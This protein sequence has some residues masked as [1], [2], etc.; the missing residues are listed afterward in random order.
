MAH[1]RSY[2]ASVTTT[3]TILDV[4]AHDVLHPSVIL[5]SQNF[6]G[7]ASGAVNPDGWTPDGTRATSFAVSPLNVGSSRGAVSGGTSSTQGPATITRTITGLTVGKSTTIAARYFSVSNNGAV[8][9]QYGQAGIVGIGTGTQVT[10]LTDSHG[11]PQPLTVAFSFVPTA[12]TH[13]AQLMVNGSNSSGLLAFWDDITVS[14]D[15]WTEHVADH[16]APAT[17]TYPLAVADG[18]V[19]LDETALPYGS[20]DMN[21]SVAT[22][23]NFGAIAATID[24]RLGSRITFNVDDQDLSTGL[25]TL[26]TFDLSVIGRVVN[27]ADGSIDVSCATDDALLAYFKRNAITPDLSFYGIAGSVRAIVQSVMAKA[28][29][30]QALAA[31]TA[32]ADMTPAFSTTNYVTNP[33]F[34]TN[35]TNAS[36][37]GGSASVTLSRQGPFGA[38]NG[39]P[40]GQYFARAT[41]TAAGGGGGPRVIGITGVNA[42]NTYTA[43][44]YVRLSRAGVSVS[45]VIEWYDINGNGITATYGNTVALPYATWTRVSGTAVAPPN[46]AKASIDFYTVGSPLANG[47]T[48]DMDAVSM[49]DGDYLPVYFDGSNPAGGNYAYAWT[50]T[51]HASTSTR[52]ATIERA[53]DALKWQP[54]DSAWDFLAPILATA[55]LRLFCDERRVW[56][57]VP[58]TYVPAGLL[59]VTLGDNLYEGTDEVNRELQ[60]VDGSPL[61]FDACLVKYTWTDLAGNTQT[62]YD[63]YSLPGGTN[64]LAT[65]E[66]DKPYP[67]PGA[68]AYWVTR[69][70]QRGRQFAITAEMDWTAQPSQEINLTFPYIDAQVGFTA[71]LEWSL[72][73]D[74]MS[75]ATRGLLNTPATAWRFQPVGKTWASVAAGVTW[76]NYS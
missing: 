61:F 11:Y 1:K 16:Y 9:P 68:A 32:D 49:T 65:I 44:G 24:P 19:R 73:E 46:A 71:S 63:S 21:V 69:S 67:G 47:D 14:T 53:P 29:I 34:E 70:A 40:A 13:V 20:I 3:Q 64:T 48:F 27:P 74:T 35:L 58:S 72:T 52:A 5:Y 59:V 25:H 62:R 76:A 43:S 18:T 60:A 28:G 37:Y 54:G 55:A 2:G 57:L 36:A 56:R 30:T 50:G 51:A 6:D 10:G 38:G 26:R 75:V 45:C 31:G 4:P 15:A 42:G 17:T 8:P 7:F 22:G 41:Y 39:V 33:S 66:Y 23:A 12:T